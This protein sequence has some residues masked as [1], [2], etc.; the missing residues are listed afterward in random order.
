MQD[1]FLVPKDE[2]EDTAAQLIF[3]GSGEQAAVVRRSFPYLIGVA[4]MTGWGP[5]L[6]VMDRF[7]AAQEI[8]FIGVAEVDII[9]IEFV[10]RGPLCIDDVGNLFVVI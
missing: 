4:H 3:F 5:S 2:S 1:V 8:K 6:D 10:G 7:N 9:A